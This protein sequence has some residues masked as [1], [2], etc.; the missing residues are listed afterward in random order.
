MMRPMRTPM[1]PSRYHTV[2]SCLNTSALMRMEKPMTPPTRELN[3][4][5]AKSRRLNPGQPVRRVQ[6]SD[7]P[8]V[9]RA[10]LVRTFPSRNF[11]TARVMQTRP[12]TTETLNRKSS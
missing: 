3:P 6:S 9:I 10:R 2:G 11:I 7:P 5:K 1:V 4:G 8:S 12:L